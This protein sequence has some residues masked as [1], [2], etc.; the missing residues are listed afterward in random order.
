[1]SVISKMR[2]KKKAKTEKWQFDFKTFPLTK[3][4]IQGLKQETNLNKEHNRETY[5][6]AMG[7]SYKVGKEMLAQ[8]PW[9]RSYI[10]S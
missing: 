3:N 7:L 9:K 8:N 4:Q 1:M 2:T 10:F 6:K 5:G